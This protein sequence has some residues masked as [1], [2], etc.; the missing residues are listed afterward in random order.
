MNKRIFL[1]VLDSFGIGELPDAE[2][3]GDLGSNTLAAISKSNY[4]QI[5]NLKKLG[6]CNIDG[7]NCCE[8]EAEILGSFARANE[9][10][11][12]K[13]TTTGHW[14]IAG[15][16]T[17]KPFPV[18]P[19]GFDDDLLE[20]IKNISG[21]DILCNK[22]YSGT[23]VI[24]DFGQSHME[25]GA[26]I[27]Y[28]S[29]DSVL[30][31]AAHEDVVPLNELYKICEDVREITDVARVIARP[32][33]GV[34]PNFERTANRHD[35]SLKPP[36]STMLDYLKNR[37]FD[38][39]AVGK[40]FDIFA[41]QGITKSIKTASNQEGIDRTIELIQTDFSGLCFVNLVDF[42][43]K[44][45]HRNDVDGYAKAIAYFDA[46]LP[47]ITSKLQKND[48]LILTADHGCD[49]STISTDHSREYIP[50]LVCGRCVKE[51]LNL[52]TLDTFADISKTILDYFEIEN[53]IPA[54]SFLS[55]ILE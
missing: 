14:E 47:E 19:N 18:Y 50:I 31:I 52:G 51:N 48:I 3:Y 53:N 27:V 49:P 30:Q 39:I 11:V 46:R 23:K 6:L 24:D 37:N 33:K 28:T 44:Y 9:K 29:A 40:I 4:F 1:I 13:D 41:S 54:T 15:V 10:S 32:F 25:T 5:D 36:A 35:F 12:G 42:D 22:P 55:K 7:V 43:M 21:R 38:T 16:I 17:Q 34:Y 45:G 2:K 26:L 8:K 20:K